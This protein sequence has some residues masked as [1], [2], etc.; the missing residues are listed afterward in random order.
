M[1]HPRLTGVFLEFIQ[2][3]YTNEISFEIVVPLLSLKL[4][5]VSP[6]IRDQS[7]NERMTDWINNPYDADHRVHYPTMDQAVN[8][9]F[10]EESIE[11][12]SEN[13]KDDVEKE[14]EEEDVQ[15]EKKKR[16]LE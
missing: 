6:S 3:R 7:L 5:N 13:N 11:H 16:L 2:T 1:I 10:I 9:L 12:D 14:G 8:E 4:I 15:V